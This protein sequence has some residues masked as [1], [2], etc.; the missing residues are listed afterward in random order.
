MTSPRSHKQKRSSIY[1]ELL[2]A[3][4]GKGCP[5]CALLTKVVKSY[6]TNLLY[7]NVNDGEVR[8]QLRR[9]SGFCRVH[10]SLL[11]SIGDPFGVAIIYQ[12]ILQSVHDR[13]STEPEESLNPGLECPACV[14]REGFEQMY[15]GI[16]IDFLDTEELRST[17]RS[18][19]GLCLNHLAQAIDRIREDDVRNELLSLHERK[20]D[21]TRRNLSEFVRKQDIQFKNETVSSE[22]EASCEQAIDFLVG[23]ND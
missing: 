22:E 1:F 6:L 18:S 2:E 7:E 4:K 19:D 16:L 5:M 12:D 3:L 14:Y 17:L 13:L 9:S 23:K 8:S 21:T 11:I 20:L 10:A 15:V